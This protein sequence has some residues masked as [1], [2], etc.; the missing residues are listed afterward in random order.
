MK[1]QPTRERGLY[2]C[3]EEDRLEK[4]NLNHTFS[5]AL[6]FTICNILTKQ[7]AHTD[8]LINGRKPG[9]RK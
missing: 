5:H 9:E 8:T 3:R 2:L 1:V 6:P 7:H 4:N